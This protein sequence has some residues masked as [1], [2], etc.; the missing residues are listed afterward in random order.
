MKDDDGLSP[1]QLGLGDMDAAEF[2]A[3]AHRVADLVADYLENL[4]SYRVLPRIEP[5]FVRERIGAE[6]PL[7][8][9]PLD[10]ILRDYAEFIEPNI[11]HW[12]HPGFMAYFP[13]VA[14]GPG[15][16]G[17]WLAAGRATRS[18]CL[19]DERSAEFNSALW[20]NGSSR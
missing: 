7:R 12:Q 20:R 10:A 6:P 2:R 8:P 9:E 13:S 14:M 3:A 19:R 5:G 18:R 16:L 4:E 17:E 15:I 11:T 1:A